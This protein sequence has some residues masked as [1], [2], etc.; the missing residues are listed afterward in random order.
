[1]FAHACMERLNSGWLLWS[2]CGNRSGELYVHIGFFDPYMEIEAVK[3][4]FILVG[5]GLVRIGS[6]ALVLNIE[7]GAR[8]TWCLRWYHMHESHWVALESHLLLYDVLLWMRDMCDNWFN[9]DFGD[10]CNICDDCVN[11]STWI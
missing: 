11:C 7:S 9:R 3:Y 5:F 4:M 8:W 10:H 1:M 6:V 2:L